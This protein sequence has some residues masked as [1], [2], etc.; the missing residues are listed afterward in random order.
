MPKKMQQHFKAAFITVMKTKHS[1][2]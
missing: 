1:M 2:L